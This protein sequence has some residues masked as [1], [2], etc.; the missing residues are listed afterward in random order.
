MIK[1]ILEKN[2]I[3][4]ENLL[5]EFY[6][7]NKIDGKYYMCYLSNTDSLD[8]IELNCQQ[9][10]KENGFKLSWLDVNE[11]QKSDIE[12]KIWVW[13]N[14]EEFKVEKNKITAIYNN[15]PNK[16]ITYLYAHDIKIINDIG[17]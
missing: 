17:E 16:L 10:I 13:V 12:E 15:F 6:T 1:E 14:C 7:D 3:E 5:N 11:I 8:M 4:I 2:G 9:Y